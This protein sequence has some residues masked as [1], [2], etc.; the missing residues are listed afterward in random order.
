MRGATFMN[1][2]REEN[3]IPEWIIFHLRKYGNC[4]CGRDIVKK[5]GKDAII[6]MLRKDGY[7]CVLRIVHDNFY[8]KPKRKVKYPL[9]AFYILEKDT[10]I[11]IYYL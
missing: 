3:V 4:C 11:K 7:D 10:P 1:F 2:S 6:E 5:I 9:N 8:E